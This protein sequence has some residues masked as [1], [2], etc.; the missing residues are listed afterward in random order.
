MKKKID[1]SYFIFLRYIFLLLLA[2][3][4]PIIYKIFTP[5]TLYPVAELLSLIYD[6]KITQNFI[7]INSEKLIQLIPAC[8]AGSA[9]LLLLILNLSTPIK[10][11][12]RIYSILLSISP[13]L[14]LNILRIFFLAVLY[15]NG[16]PFFDLTHKLLWYGLSI[17]FVIGI[18]FL[19]VKIFSIHEIPIYSDFKFFLK[20]IKK[21]SKN[22]ETSKGN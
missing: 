3:S 12:K 6:V 1:K 18:W 4:L 13:L 11:K 16:S 5:L 15:E 21:N 7:L 10:L 14:I 2:F 19:I 8:I 17:I 9:Y 20:S 22:T